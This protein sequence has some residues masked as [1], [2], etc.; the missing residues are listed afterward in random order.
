MSLSF[1]SL[2]LSES[3]VHRLEALDFKV[4]TTIQAEAIP[5]LLAGTDVVGQAQTGTGKTAAF[6]LPI[7]E[8]IDASSKTVQALI[9]TPTRELAMQVSQAIHRLNY[10]PRL[11]TLA[12]YGG[13]DI[14]RHISQLARG[15]QILVGTPGRILDLLNRGD[16][17]LNHLSWLVLDEADEML[18]MGFIQDV[19]QILSQAPAERQTA[20][21][22]ATLEPAIRKLAAQFLRS[23]LTIMTEQQKAAP[24]RIQQVAY[25]LPTG[26]SK[27][28]AL[29]PILELENPESALIFVRTR[30]TAAELTSQLQ[31]A[32]HSV[33]EY[34]G[35]LNQTQRE[36]LIARFR[37]Q[38]VRWVVATDVA[39]RGLHMDH[40][41]HVINYDL[42]D[43]AES[44][45]HRI[46]RTGRAGK[47]GT[48]ISLVQPQDRYKIRN[49]ERYTN[50]KL[51]VYSI[52]TRTQ[53][54]ACHLKRLQKRVQEALTGERL[55]SFLPIVAQLSQE[56]DIHAIAA[57]ALQMAY[58]QSC[59]AGIKPE[60]I[61]PGLDQG[62]PGLNRRI[63]KR[64]SGRPAGNLKP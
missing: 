50:Q 13:Q 48:A 3:C 15:V 37:Q 32:G 30:R 59:P 29:Q 36:R 52:P 11:K 49:I 64:G 58:D 41:T 42:P 25:K 1:K 23:P 61:K 20:F 9:L 21:F 4:P 53:I 5:P 17:K 60:E 57:A 43:N 16:L 55:A 19:K 34:H 27:I 47:S 12:V 40:I 46:G 2:G 44:Y 35:D 7:L 45:V 28:R 62:E 38:Q 22:S 6:V 31:M 14:R 8:R 18:N 39:A 63:V 26:C 56:Y 33:D 24:A 54:E 51:E 10:D